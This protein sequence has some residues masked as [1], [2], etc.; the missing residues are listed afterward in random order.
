MTISPPSKVKLTPDE[1]AR[2]LS[3]GIDSL[4]LTIDVLWSDLKGFEALGRMKAEAM[5]KD[6]DIPGRSITAADAEVFFFSVRPFGAGGYEWLIDSKDLSLKVGNWE[7][8][9]SRPSVV[10]EIRSEA[11]WTHGVDRMVERV[12]RILESW[13]GEVQRVRV[14]RVDVC[15]DVLLRESDWSLELLDQFVTRAHDI[16]PY[17][18]RRI[19]TGFQIGKGAVMARLYDKPLEIRNKSGKIWMYPIWGID[20]VPEGHRVIR[21]EYQLRRETLKMLGIDGVS[22][23]LGGL[24]PLWAYCTQ[25][26]LKV[27]TG[28]G[29]H[30]TQRYTVAWWKVVQDGVTGAVDASPVVR[31]IAGVAEADRLIAMIRSY[32]ISYTALMLDGNCIP[33]DETVCYRDAI[34]IVKQ[35]MVASDFTDEEFTEKVKAKQ[36]KITRTREKARLASGA[37]DDP[38]VS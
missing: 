34:Q 16:N 36:A 7:E 15:V 35:H 31:R 12:N 17:T 33:K 8:P 11:L 27:Q 1:P 18:S 5:S 32:V 29:D 10:V 19:L 28:T 24:I 2:V 3:T 4:V 23:L 38:A 22:D 26:W 21:V 14:S 13:G 20:V 6:Q 25:S 37:V 30:H 9:M